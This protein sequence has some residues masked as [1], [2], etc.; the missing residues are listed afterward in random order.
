MLAADGV[1]GSTII[2]TMTDSGGHARAT[3]VIGAH[4]GAGNN[5]VRAAAAGF[6]GIVEFQATGRLDV[7]VLVV[8]DAGN[9]QFGA[10]G[11]P[12]PRP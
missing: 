4:A 3:W 11:S 9:A 2:T 7:P 1:G 5:R 10:F 6:A 12:L 8:V